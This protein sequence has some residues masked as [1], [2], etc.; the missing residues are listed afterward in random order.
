MAV[1]LRQ[2]LKVG[3]Y[4]ISQRL[5]GRQRFPSIDARASISL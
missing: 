4:I 3:T 2:A 5:A 1:Q